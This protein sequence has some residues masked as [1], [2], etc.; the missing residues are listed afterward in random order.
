MSGNIWVPTA[1][2]DFWT[3][4]FLLYLFIIKH[5]DSISE[6]RFITSFDLLKTLRFRCSYN[7]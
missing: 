4:S 6:F 5:P 7:Y 2:A 1:T 3:G